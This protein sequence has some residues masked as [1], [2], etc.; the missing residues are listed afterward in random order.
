MQGD[1]CDYETCLQACKDIHLIS[2]QTALGSVPRSIK[3]PF[4]T[5]A[6]N[7]TGSLKIFNPAVACGVQRVVFAA[8]SSTIGDSEGLPKL[9]SIIG[10]PLSPYSVTKY[11]NELYAEVYAR[12]YEFKYVGLR[13]FNVFGPKQDPYGAYAAVIPL[14]FKAAL[15]GTGATINGN[16]ENS[17]DFT[18]VGNAI[19]ANMLFLFSENPTAINQV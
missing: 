6:V 10:K 15:D 17:R 2:H 11:I 3:D 19:E 7:I 8:S 16:G 14:F 4:T 5:N 1:I 18:Y 9:E 12:T 13:Y